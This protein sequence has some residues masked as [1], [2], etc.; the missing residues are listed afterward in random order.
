MTFT[1]EDKRDKIRSQLLFELTHPEPPKIQ[2]DKSQ[3]GLCSKRHK[4][5]QNPKNRKQP[6]EKRYW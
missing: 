2:T 1:L 6:G 5:L 3:G 4:F